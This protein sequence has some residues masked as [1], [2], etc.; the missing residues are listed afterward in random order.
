MTNGLIGST[1]FEASDRTASLADAAE[2]LRV[3]RRAH[4]RFLALWAADHLMADAT[5]AVTVAVGVA[6]RTDNRVNLCGLDR[7]LFPDEPLDD[8]R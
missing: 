7:G 2:R 5:A 4:G 3:V 6:A 1:G 8:D